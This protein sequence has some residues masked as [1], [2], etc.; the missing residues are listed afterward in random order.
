MRP[1][2]FFLLIAL[3]CASV[4]AEELDP[5]STHAVIVGVLEWKNGL[6]PYPKEH[7]KDQELCDTLVH[8]G[9]PRENIA[10]LLDREATLANVRA[11][12]TRTAHEAGPGSTLLVY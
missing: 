5:A 10:L 6:Q 7:R 8:R 11:A 12:V 9:T 2:A 1:T 4:R 3:W